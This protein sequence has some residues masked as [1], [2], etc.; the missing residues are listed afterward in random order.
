MAE[1]SEG[2]AAVAGEEA[3]EHGEDVAAVEKRNVFAC[4]LVRVVA[5]GEEQS[6]LAWWR[7]SRLR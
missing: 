1:T 6:L 7:A 4:P 5:V 3:E 2:V